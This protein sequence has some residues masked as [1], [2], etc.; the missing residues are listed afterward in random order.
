M[1]EQP[2]EVVL[3]CRVRGLIERAASSGRDVVD[4]C[5]GFGLRERGNLLV[6]EN[7]RDGTHVA[8]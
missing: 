5:L 8:C 1:F 4:L 6:G 3:E 2:R 7:F